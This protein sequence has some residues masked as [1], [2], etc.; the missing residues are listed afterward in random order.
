MDMD[1][2]SD[3]N[4]GQSAR[5]SAGYDATNNIAWQRG[6]SNHGE[7]PAYDDYYAG[8][9]LIAGVQPGE[10]IVP[11]GTYNLANDVYL[12]PQSPWGWRDGQFYQLAKGTTVGAIQ[13]PDSLKDRSQIVTARKIPAGNTAT[14]RASFTLVE[15]IGSTGLAE[16][17]SRVASAR[18]WVQG[19]PFILCGDINNDGSVDAGDIIGQINYLYKGFPNSIVEPRMRGDVNSSGSIEIGDIVLMISYLYKSGPIPKCPGI[20]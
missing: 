9:A 16:L 13:F 11:A 19:K 8:M 1:C 14:T 2:P 12:Y 6:R 3:T 7:H 20:W 15:T 18:A 17:Q 5:N 10:S 4:A